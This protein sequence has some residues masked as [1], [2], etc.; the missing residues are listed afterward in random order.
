MRSDLL[1]NKEDVLQYLKGRFPMFH[2]SNVFFRD[3]QYGIQLLLK[4]Q[5]SDVNYASAERHARDFTSA[6]E[7][8]GVLVPVDP[9]TWVLNYPPFKTPVVKTSGPVAP[10]ATP[11]AIPAGTAGVKP[12]PSG[13]GQGP[14]SG[15]QPPV[16]GKGVV[17]GVPGT[18][19]PAK[20]SDPD[21]KEHPP[22]PES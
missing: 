4:E 19:S 10:S 1:Q 14:A 17:S 18:P 15:A 2:Q 20:P 16:R 6:L 22:T 11:G 5:G 8:D 3:I 13:A 21:G 12:S 7:K 9:Q